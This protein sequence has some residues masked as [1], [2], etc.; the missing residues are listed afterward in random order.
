MVTFNLVC[1][2]WIFFRAKTL[3]DAIYVLTHLGVIDNSTLANLINI[4]SVRE[5]LVLVFLL[6]L[7]VSVSCLSKGRSLLEVPLRL[8]WGIY[9]CLALA[10][11]VFSRSSESFIYFRF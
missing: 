2:A 11:M 1:V 3:D 10:I 8:R 5:G 4:T 6:T 7:T 9:Y